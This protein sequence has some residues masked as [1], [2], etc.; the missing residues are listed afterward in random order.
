MNLDA[1]SLEDDPKA[2]LALHELLDEP[3]ADQFLTE[4]EREVRTHTRE[5]VAHEVAPRAAGLD[6]HHT[7]AHDSVQAL[8]RA[9]LCGLIF[10]EDLGGTGDSN[11]AYAIAMEEITAGCAATSLVFMTQM[12]AAY[13]IMIAGSDELQRRYVP[14]LLDGSAYGSLGI[15]EPGAGSDVSGVTTTARPTG[16]GWSLSGQK[17]FITSGDRADVIICFATVDRSLG[18]RGIT[19]FVL[20]GAWDGIGRGVPFDKMGMHGSSTAE[21]FFDHVPI[22]RTHLL[23]E[24]GGG[25]SVVMRSVVKSR[26]SAAAQGVGLAKAA[27][28]RTLAALRSH[29]GSRIP[30]EAT[31]ALAELR[32]RI[33]QGR[34]LLHGVARRVD[35]DPDITPGQI[36]MMKQTCTDL[37]FSASV[38][39]A[40]ILGPHGDLAALG[41]ERCLRDA[42]VTQIYDGTNEIQRLLIGRETNRAIKELA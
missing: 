13:P 6:E 12:H 18:R 4:R 10:P 15:T 41:V 7:F 37:G 40:R 35:T 2:Y 39:A 3:V 9:G 36:G 1:P 8:A 17:T 38:E 30:D 34:L 28:A 27:Y 33:L 32:G 29:H 5:V 14:G 24:E 23:G 31:F 22:P 25:W 21:L 26:I 42:K 19:A 11:V 16:E 20:D